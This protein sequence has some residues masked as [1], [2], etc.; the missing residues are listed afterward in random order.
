M[1]KGLEAK[2]MQSKSPQKDLSVF[3]DFEFDMHGGQSFKK[4]NSS[5]DATT[6]RCEYRVRHIQ[7]FPLRALL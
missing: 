5:L 2:L 4:T 7:K 6:D 1:F 3:I